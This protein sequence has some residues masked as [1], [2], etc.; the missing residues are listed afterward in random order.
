MIA[1]RHDV[2][3]AAE[4]L[5]PDLPGDAE[6]RGGVLDIGDDHQVDLM[7]VDESRQALA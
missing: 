5:I 1:R 4:D 6:A 7:V 2:D 3:A